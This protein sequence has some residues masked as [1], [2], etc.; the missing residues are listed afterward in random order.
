MA[1]SSCTDVGSLGTLVGVEFA[2][3]M[4]ARVVHGAV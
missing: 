3:G 2:G 1:A 4:P